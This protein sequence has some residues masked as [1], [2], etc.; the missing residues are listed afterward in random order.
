MPESTM[1]GV[2]AEAGAALPRAFGSFTLLKQIAHGERGDVFA[3]LRPVEIER[4]CA[5]KM[6]PDEIARQP[7]FIPSLRN[8]AT[9]VVRRIHDNLVQIYDVGLFDQ[10]LFFVTE[11][12]E[13]CDLA[14][15]GRT[16]RERRQQFPVDVAVY[17]TMEIAAALSYLRRLGARAG[18]S[19]PLPAGLSP[20]SIILSVDGE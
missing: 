1:R 18:E 3:A 12:V 6:L 4:F 2:A 9:R 10:R 16:L 20:R 13:G 8:E 11:L 5:I 14:T 19:S 17:V 7:E 15:L